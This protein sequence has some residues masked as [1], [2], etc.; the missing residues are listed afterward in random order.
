MGKIA[1][2]FSH[3]TTKT[4][5]YLF[6]IQLVNILTLA[7]KIL[8][9]SYCELTTKIEVAVP[10]K[11]SSSVL[12]DWTYLSFDISSARQKFDQPV[13]FVEDSSAH[14]H[15]SSR[16]LLVFRVLRNVSIVKLI[17]KLHSPCIQA[18]KGVCC[19]VRVVM[20]D[21]IKETKLRLSDPSDQR[22][23]Y[24]EQRRYI[25]YFTPSPS[26]P[27]VTKRVE[28]NDRKQRAGLG[29]HGPQ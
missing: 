29:V 15:R 25:N 14:L 5:V 1:R 11:S 3:R 12:K 23:R 18:L 10:G 13:T 17:P 9:F 4:E 6:T 16:E 26:C 2:G 21:N 22:R 7:T 20:D 24:C 19:R 27:M 8:Q 28:Y